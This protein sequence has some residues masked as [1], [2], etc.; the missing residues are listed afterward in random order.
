[1][2]ADLS[3]ILGPGRTALM[4]FQHPDAADRTVII[5]TAGIAEDLL[6][7]SKALW[8]PIVQ[9]GC[10]G[11]L[12]VVNL[13]SIEPQTLA[14]LIGPSYYLGNPG[15]TASGPELHKHAPFPVAGRTA[16]DIAGSVR[17]DP[18]NSETPPRAAAES[19]RGMIDGE[20]LLKTNAP[21]DLN[22]Q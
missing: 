3:G 11:D 6:A 1:M 19:L 14:H 13:D 22:G 10:Q 21:H 16:G 9:G 20:H 17:I 12:V 7:G 8:D 15:R 5:L 4:Q 18:E 2:G